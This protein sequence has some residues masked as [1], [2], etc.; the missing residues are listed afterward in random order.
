MK[1]ILCGYNWSA[2]KALELLI[3]ENH[4]VFVYTH[5]NP[6][7]TVSLVDYCTKV[8][9]QFSLEKISIQNIPFKPDIICSIYYQYII[10]KDIIELVQG[11]IFNLHPSLL[12]DYKGCSS[13][14]W[15]M[16]NGEKTTGYTFH[17]INPRIDEGNIIYQEEIEIE[18][19][20]TGLTLYYKAMFK[21]M[22]SFLKVLK[23]VNEGYSGNEQINLAT[24]RYF[25]RGAPYNGFIDENWDFDKIERFIRAMNFPPMLPARLQGKNINTIKDYLTLKNE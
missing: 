15:A 8:D 22:Q 2:C 13:L 3:R 20:D 10:D 6:A 7:F 24:S 5:E 11:K 1:V 4:Q 25:K 12:P 21:A 9:I 14:T 23:L 19:F 16:V 17:Y 18:D